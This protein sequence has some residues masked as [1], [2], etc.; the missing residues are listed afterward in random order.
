[1][2]TITEQGILDSPLSEKTQKIKPTLLGRMTELWAQISVHS[3]RL[4]FDWCTNILQTATQ[5]NVSVPWKLTTVYDIVDAGPRHCF[6]V[7]GIENEWKRAHNC[8]YS[9][10]E[11]Y[12]AP[13]LSG[14]PG[15][16]RAYTSG[17][18]YLAF[19]IATGAAPADATKHSHKDIRTL[20]KST[21]LGL[22][23]GMGAAKLA[24]KL[25]ADTG[26]TVGVEEAK[27]LIRQHREVYPVYYE[28][29]ERLWEQYRYEQQPLVLRDGWYLDVDQL[30][31]LSALNFPIQGTGSSIM[32][33]CIDMLYDEGI[34]LICP[35]HD[36]MVVECDIED[37]DR[38]TE[39]V[40][41]CMLSSSAKVLG[42]DEMRV[43]EPESVAH[44][45]YWETEK[46]VYDLPKFKKY[47]ENSMNYN[48]NE[49]MLKKVLNLS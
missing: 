4:A 23:Y 46:N 30:S 33:V 12:I 36:S 16:L 7:K 39:I 26:R 27:E 19:A 47:F 13:I 17:D 10:Q 42:A 14:D 41:K 43:G 15:L 1:M 44:G 5:Q 35:I 11:A 37:S 38:V 49:K 20:Y 32:R 34:E 18:P 2:M 21:V 40:A 29:K 31:R 6:L 24:I 45:E 48:A 3:L 22:Q 25:S 9:S 28:W 8:D